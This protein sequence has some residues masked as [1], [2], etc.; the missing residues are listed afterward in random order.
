MHY[1]G[2]V[3][4]SKGSQGIETQV[5]TPHRGHETDILYLEFL[6]RFCTP[7]YIC[8]VGMII[9]YS[10]LFRSDALLSGPCICSE[11]I[12]YARSDRERR[13]QLL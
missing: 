2:F 12:N 5:T 7:P 4:C 10:A 3:S 11:M 9:T 8:L 13:D 1:F 6:G